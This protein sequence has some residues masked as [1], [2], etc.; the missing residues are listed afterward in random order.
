MRFASLSAAAHAL[1]ETLAVVLP[2]GELEIAELLHVVSAHFP[3]RDVFFAIEELAAADV[4]HER[5]GK[6]SCPQRALLERQASAMSPAQLR[7]R[8]E[9]LGHVYRARGESFAFRAAYHYWRAGLDELLGPLL[10]LGAVSAGRP[11]L[12]HDDNRALMY[13][14]PVH[15]MAVDRYERERA[16]GAPRVELYRVRKLILQAAA[17]VKPELVRYAPETI[18][19]LRFDLG[20]D[21]WDEL[22]PQLDPG[23][24]LFQCLERAQARSAALPEA[25]RGLSVADAISET[26]SSVM[27]LTGPYAVTYDVKGITELNEL[28]RPLAVLAPVLRVVADFTE[29]AY[30]SLVL[31]A[32]AAAYRKSA[33]AILAQPID[34]LDETTR[35]TVLRLNK[36]YFAM[37]IAAEG[38]DDALAFAE[39]LELEP[40][41]EALGLQIRR[42]HALMRGRYT[43]AQKYRAHREQLALQS[44]DT[45]QH[46]HMSMLRELQAANVGNDYLEASRVAVAIRARA[47]RYPGWRPW[48]LVALAFQRVAAGAYAEGEAILR[49]QFT[50]IEPFTHGAWEQ[51]ALMLAQLLVM[52]RA[53][54]EA[55][56]VLAPIRDRAI[57]LGVE[58]DINRQ[59]RACL[60]LAKAGLGEAA[61]AER[62]LDSLVELTGS[63]IPGTVPYALMCQARA[64]LA[65]MQ[66]DGAT[67]ERMLGRIRPIFCDGKHPGLSANY[68]Q[69]TTRMQ[70][71]TG[72]EIVSQH[73]HD[74]DRLNDPEDGPRDAQRGRARRLPAIGAACRARSRAGLRIPVRQP[75]PA[76]AGRVSQHRHG[77]SAHCAGRQAGQRAWPDRR[78]VVGYRDGGR[79]R[80]PLDA[81]RSARSLVRAPLALEP[82]RFP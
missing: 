7:D 74:A 49:E 62:E 38:R 6:Y 23:A 56:A 59:M 69:L 36:Y 72:D 25:E 39:E 8:H 64:E 15:E 52:R 29:A 68:E 34:G 4:L 47:E 28:I 30:T 33:M 58:L 26:A 19:Q 66:N 20:L 32:T 10:A 82:R 42:I 53:Y 16:R 80:D 17:W 46:L 63:T 55:Q 41:F 3:E 37:E 24:R 50:A 35:D 2:N 11:S 71:R 51:T 79:D 61:E 14:G 45:D 57:E 73:E 81:A 1:I 78:R 40:A 60:A 22:D 9:Q 76:H 27:L 43:A 70:P 67:I 12:G 48:L 31:G 77:R 44:E 65:V 5:A 21:L 75:A 18:A 13:S 54:A